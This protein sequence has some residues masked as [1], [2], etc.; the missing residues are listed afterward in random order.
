M[1]FLFFFHTRRVGWVGFGKYGKFQSFFLKP[2]LRKSF[3]YWI[4]ENIRIS[5]AEWKDVTIKEIF[6]L[7]G[8]QFLELNWYYKEMTAKQKKLLNAI[9]DSS[10]F[11]DEFR[12]FLSEKTNGRTS[13][14]QFNATVYYNN[15][16]LY[17]RVEE[18][19][20]NLGEYTQDTKK[21]YHKNFFTGK[22]TE[23]QS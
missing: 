22:G 2:S 21:T 15:L 13:F 16:H 23:R 3:I 4:Y 1:L 20:D 7:I 9:L 18:S 5:D 17:H 10:F 11:E 14:D 12:N 8:S 19:V 6:Q